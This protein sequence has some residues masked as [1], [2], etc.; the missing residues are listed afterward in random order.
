MRKVEKLHNEEPA[1]S[2]SSPNIT[3]GEQMQR[4]EIRD[5]R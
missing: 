1:C 2:Y 4:D 5:T 3:K